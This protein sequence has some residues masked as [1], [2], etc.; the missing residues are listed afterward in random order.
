MFSILIVDDNYSD[1]IG[2]HGLIEWDQLGIEVVG[3]AVDGADG[4][5]QAVQLR[6][7]FILTDVAMPVM[8]GL[9]MTQH[10][11]EE[12]PDTKFIFMSCFDDF[13][14]LKGAINLEVYGYILKPIDLSELTDSLYKVKQLRELELEKEQS[15][16]NL[17]KRIQES[18]PVLQEQLIRDLLS[19]K[20]E[21]E[22]EIRERMQYLGMPFPFE[23]YSVLFLQI[24]NYETLYVD[25]TTEERHLLIYSVQKC[26]EETILNELP[27]YITSQ[28]YSS[29]AIILLAKERESEEGLNGIVEAANR[30]K[31]KVNS[32]IGMQVTIGISDVSGRLGELPKLY[33]AAQYAVKSKFYSSGNRIILASEARAPEADFQYNM[34]EIKQKIEGLLERGSEEDIVHFINHCY[35]ADIRYPETYIKSLTYSIIQIMHMILLERQESYSSIYGNDLVVWD[36]LQRFETIEDIKQWLVSII[37]TVRSFVHKGESGRY[38]K[39]IEDIK[40]IIDETYAEIENVGQI[41]ASLYISASHANFI[42]K[43]QTGQTIFDYLMMKRMEAAKRLLMDPYMK[44]YEIAEKTG[45]KTTSYFTSVFKE[46]TGVTPKQFRDKYDKK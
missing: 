7:D 14:Y 23:G 28:S 36:K 24:D 9:K 19:G 41:V 21:S 33:E 25:I 6:P 27:G 22:G 15:D 31:E 2:I 29:A 16:Q 42:F 30:C 46:Y 10:I 26:I 37:E 5:K 4:Y 1:R 44:I 38:G 3:L 8:D 11:K 43:Q 39:V 45:Y 35:H 13:D 32:S 18:M 20:F 12:L 40:S 17:R 34:L